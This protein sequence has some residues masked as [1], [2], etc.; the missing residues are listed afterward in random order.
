MPPFPS[1][2]FDLVLALSFIEHIG[3]DNSLYFARREAASQTGDLDAARSLFHLL[4]PGGRLLVTVPFGGLEDHGWFVQYDA[5]RVDELVA[6]T[7]GQLTVAEYYGYQST[8]WEGPLPRE[9]LKNAQYRS[10]PAASARA[11]AVACLELTRA[12]L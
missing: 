11:S 8:G 7:G 12:N 9:Q 2:S 1:G 10:Q 4:R 6:A 3:R 5:A